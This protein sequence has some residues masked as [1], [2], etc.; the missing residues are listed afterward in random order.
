MEK[1]SPLNVE[2]SDIHHH[3]VYKTVIS[4]LPDLAYIVDK[5][6]CF[7]HCTLNFLTYLNLSA[8]EDT[9]P[10]SIYK[11]MLQSGHWTEKQIQEMKTKDIETLLSGSPRPEVSTLQVVDKEDKIH[12]YE[13]SRIPILD[14]TR[15]TM[16]LLVIFKDITQQLYLH[17]Q[18]EGIKAQLQHLNGQAGQVIHSGATQTIPDRS[19]NVLVVEDNMIA[20]K[21]ARG[22]LM[23]MDCTVDIAKSEA[24]LLE[25]FSPG[26]YDLIF[27]DIGLEETSG[28]MLAKQIR[29]QEKN[30]AHRAPIIALTGYKADMLAAD[31]AYYQM[32]GAITKPLTLEQARQL[33]QRYILN[34]DIPVTGLKLASGQVP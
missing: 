31:C 4:H 17:Q 34:I 11:I 24:Q 18:Y 23:Q 13:L 9:H 12:H 27:M 14:D 10:G 15:A 30:T 32:E 3:I 33:V 28:Y 5:N 8:I 21:A 20:Q 6:C 19:L 2:T 22:I 16:A 25:I 7:I 1:P 29:S 26:K